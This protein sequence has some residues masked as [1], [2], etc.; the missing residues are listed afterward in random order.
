MASQEELI[1]AVMNLMNGHDG[2][3]SSYLNRA[4]IV[5]GGTNT[6]SEDVKR[7]QALPTAL[8]T[9]LKNL[10][11]RLTAIEAKGTGSASTKI[12]EADALYAQINKNIDTLEAT[13]ASIEKDVGISK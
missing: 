12:K 6:I 5:Q 9:R 3:R 8:D 10:L 2:T 4:K 11:P 7:V 13:I 1:Q